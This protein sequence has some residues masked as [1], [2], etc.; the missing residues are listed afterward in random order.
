MVREG[1]ENGQSLARNRVWLVICG[2]KSNGYLTLVKHATISGINQA[3][4]IWGLGYGR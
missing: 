1:V 2:V 4:D 3:S